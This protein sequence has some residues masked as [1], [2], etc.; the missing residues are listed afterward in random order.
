MNETTSP[1]VK[2]PNTT[3]TCQ[4]ETKPAPTA[5][6]PQPAAAATPAPNAPKMSKRMRKR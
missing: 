2:E 6:Q 3:C 5:A 1:A 4:G